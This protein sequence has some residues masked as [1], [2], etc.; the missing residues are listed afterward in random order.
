MKVE[1]SLR[2]IESVINKG[3]LIGFILTVGLGAIN[4]GY[5]IGVFNSL[6]TDFLLVFGIEKDDRGFWSSLLTTICA[7]GAFTGSISAGAFV[8]FGKKKCIHV[9]NIILAIGCILC[10]V[11]NIYVVTVGR[12]I[13]GLSAGSFSVFVPSY[14]NEVTPTEL[15][16]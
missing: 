10:L 9:N 16:G 4:F 11:K 5:S 3:F 2:P 14:I 6:M 7:L 15:K 8:K 13:F 1:G 12:F